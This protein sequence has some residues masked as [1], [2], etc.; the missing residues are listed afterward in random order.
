MGSSSSAKTISLTSEYLMAHENAAQLSMRLQARREVNFVAN[1]GVIHAV[2]APEV[3]HRAV[4]RV[5]SDPQLE[6][7]F[8]SGIA[9]L[10]LE[11]SHS[12]LHRDGHLDA[13]HRILLDP[14]R[15]RIAEERHDRIA[16]VL[17]DGRTMLESD[18]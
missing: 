15:L 5:D 11:L 17:V 8:Q 6:R 14:L 12:L 2:L 7:L 9:P 18:L 3:A 1:D 4:T 10:E 13:C 16:N